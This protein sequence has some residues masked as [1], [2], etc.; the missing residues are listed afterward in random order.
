MSVESPNR[1]SLTGQARSTSSSIA[2]WSSR[3]PRSSASSWEI[4]GGTWRQG[5]HVLGRSAPLRRLHPPD[6]EYL[7]WSGVDESDRG[8]A[9]GREHLDGRGGGGRLDRPTPGPH[10]RAE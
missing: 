8:N 10:Q 4:N 2:V 7:G 1:S 6:R 9:A 3:R 5:R